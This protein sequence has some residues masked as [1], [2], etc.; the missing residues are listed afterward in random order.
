MC[1]FVHVHIYLRL[2]SWEWKSLVHMNTCYFESCHPI[3][4]H[5]VVPVH[6]PPA[7]LTRANWFYLNGLEAITQGEEQG[8]PLPCWPLNSKP[9]HPCGLSQDTFDIRILMAKSVKYTVNF[10]EAKEGDLHRYQPSR[11]SSWATAGSCRHSTAPGQ[12]SGPR[13][14]TLHLA[15]PLLSYQ[16]PFS[17]PSNHCPLLSRIEIPFK[18]HM[19]HSGLVHGL[20]FWFD[21][22]FIGSM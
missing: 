6:P 13:S 9:G 1:K 11:P 22:A 12:A 4:L 2:N 16:P 14:G 10:L 15:I 7:C 20:A 8:S 19:L 3:V 17:F 21:V 5:C 18:F